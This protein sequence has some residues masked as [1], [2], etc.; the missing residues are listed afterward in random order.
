M[1][2]FTELYVTEQQALINSKNDLLQTII[3][4][5]ANTPKTSFLLT[6]RNDLIQRRVFGENLDEQEAHDINE[7]VNSISTMLANH[8]SIF[9]ENGA[10]GSYSSATIYQAI[11]TYLNNENPIQAEFYQ[12]NKQHFLNSYP[13]AQNDIVSSAFAFNKS[14]STLLDKADNGKI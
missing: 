5:G 13:L 11:S 7:Q 3:A 10:Q 12:Y 8:N 9:A 14:V 2:N 6:Q 1:H 4:S